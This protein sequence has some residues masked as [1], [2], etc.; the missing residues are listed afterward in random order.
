MSFAQNFSRK[1]RKLSVGGVIILNR[2]SDT[3]TVRD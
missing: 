1:I 2:I 3:L